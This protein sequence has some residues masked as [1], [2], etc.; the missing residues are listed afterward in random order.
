MF[1]LLFADVL[2]APLFGLGLM[3]AVALAAAAWLLLRRTV[4]HRT[5]EARAAFERETKLQEQLRQSQKLEAV[6][7]LAGG[8]AHDFNNL[9]TV[10][11]GCGELLT[12]TL[13]EGH[14]GRE[15]AKDIRGAGERA[16]G[17]VGQLLLF[18]RHR[19]V[20]PS[21]VD[22]NAIVADA[23]KLLSRVIPATIAVEADYVN[24]PPVRA[25]IGLHQVI[26][27]L[28][29]NARDA[30]PEGGILR[31]RTA[32][33]E[34]GVGGRLIVEDTGTGMD[35]ATKARIYE[36]F[37]TTKEIGKGT[38]LGL[39]TVYGIVNALGGTIR[40]QSTVGLG[41]VFEIDFAPSGSGKVARPAIIADSKVFPMIGR[42]LGTVL[43]VEDDDGVRLLTRRILEGGHYDVI[44]YGNPNEALA[45]AANAR[46]IDLLLT[47]VVMPGM[48]GRALA[49]T[50]L[51]ERPEL[52]VLYMSGYAPDDVL[53]T[54]VL[55]DTAAFLP[56][57]FTPARLLERVG[58]MLGLPT[59]A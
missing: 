49:E 30:M 34:S 45:A 10:I 39:A 50:L 40:F 24:L 19:T 43:L 23:V 4:R 11:N 26:M 55:D 36:P 54:G 58:E 35:E 28:A 17:L 6:G 46:R 14:V 12:E 47:D 41:T 53:R 3:L 42:S 48:N 31:I 7:R 2:I 15:L 56:K 37:F 16:A 29:L 18:S 57:P 5:E 1:E 9:L 33:P 21:A 52:R 8:I 51:R 32:V 38:G 20:T 13:P 59:A 44:A 27:N 22:L 25:D